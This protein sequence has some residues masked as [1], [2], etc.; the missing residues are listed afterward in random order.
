M[1]GHIKMNYKTYGESLLCSVVFLLAAEYYIRIKSYTLF[2]RNK[3]G[4][5]VLMG[6]LMNIRTFFEMYNFK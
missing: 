5:L 1:L 6:E 2:D 4:L 3:V